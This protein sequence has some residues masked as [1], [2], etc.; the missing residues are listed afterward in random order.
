[1]KFWASILLALLVSGC[2]VLRHDSLVEGIFPDEAEY[3]EH[4]IPVE[5][6]WA[7]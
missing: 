5:G 3:A 6:D 4:G 2:A 1:M 7:R